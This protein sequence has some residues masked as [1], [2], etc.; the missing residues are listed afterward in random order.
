MTIPWKW[1]IK[2]RLLCTWKSTGGEES[3]I[4]VIP[5]I[6]KIENKGKKP[7]HGGSRSEHVL[8]IW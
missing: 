1:A 6:T 7:E 5:P 2:N 3:R 4:P 8:E